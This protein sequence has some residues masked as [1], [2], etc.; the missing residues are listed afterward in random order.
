MP[1]LDIEVKECMFFIAKFKSIF[2]YPSSK[3]LGKYPFIFIIVA[4]FCTFKTSKI[5]KSSHWFKA[6][7]ILFICST[8]VVLTTAYLK[9]VK[10]YFLY[11][12]EKGLEIYGY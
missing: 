4:K 10:Y 1:L 8:A 9:Q 12:L 11:F 5:E 7:K 2:F 6:F 3:V